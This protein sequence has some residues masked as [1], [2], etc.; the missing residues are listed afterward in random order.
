LAHC[1]QK[2]LD[3]WGTTHYLIWNRI[4]AP[5]LRHACMI[6]GYMEKQT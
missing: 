4:S 5:S 6:L 3:L 1:P 2:K